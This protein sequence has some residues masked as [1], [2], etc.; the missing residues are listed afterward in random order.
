MQEL[1]KLV[2][3]LGVQDHIAQIGGHRTDLREIMAVSD[4]VYSLSREPEAFGRTTVEALALGT[5]VMGYDHGGVGE[6]LAAI[7]PQGRIALGDM[8]ALEA[9]SAYWLA[10]PPQVPSTQPFTLKRMVTDTLAVYSELIATC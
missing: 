1:H 6:Q 3:T 10:Q 4:I 5:P 8:A 7:L 9:L 2:S